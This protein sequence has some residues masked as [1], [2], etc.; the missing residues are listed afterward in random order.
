LGVDYFNKI[1]APSKEL[2]LIKEAKHS[3]MLE[4]PDE[5]LKAM[6]KVVGC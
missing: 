4:K 3:P 6:R 1:E 5:F 2:I